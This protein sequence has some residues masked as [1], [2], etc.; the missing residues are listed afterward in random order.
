MKRK[1][2]QAL[3]CVLAVALSASSL[4]ACGTSVIPEATTASGTENSQDASEQT[5]TGPTAS[6]REAR[7][8]RPAKVMPSPIQLLFM[9]T[10]QTSLSKA[11]TTMWQT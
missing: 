8:P 2:I 3:S 4:S 6:S 11:G 7:E 10:M 1:N 9:F 5:E